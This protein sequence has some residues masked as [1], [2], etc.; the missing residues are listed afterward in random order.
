MCEKLFYRKVYNN[1]LK[2]WEK[3]TKM[4]IEKPE[5]PIIQ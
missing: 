1:H 5:Y 3:W 4:L 2:Q